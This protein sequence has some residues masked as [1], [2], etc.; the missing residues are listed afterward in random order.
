M[1]PTLN[2]L[3]RFG[4]I[5]RLFGFAMIQ[6]SNHISTK[7]VS[8]PPGIPNRHNQ[9]PKLSS[10]DQFALFQHPESIRHVPN[11]SSRQ[12]SEKKNT[13]QLQSFVNK[14]NKAVSLQV[15]LSQILFTVK[16][17]QGSDNTKCF[18]LYFTILFSSANLQTYSERGQYFNNWTD[19]V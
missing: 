15:L 13:Q 11:Y 16:A 9:I 1:I 18:N 2:Y 17:Y 14:N 3:A 8:I 10:P 7:L 12:F 19:Q 6:I 4:G 5:S